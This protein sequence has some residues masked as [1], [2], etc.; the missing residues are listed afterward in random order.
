MADITDNQIIELSLIYNTCT[1]A[2][3]KNDNDFLRDAA[4]NGYGYVSLRNSGHN[5]DDAK[6]IFTSTCNTDGRYDTPMWTDDEDVEFTSRWIN[7]YSIIGRLAKQNRQENARDIIYWVKIYYESYGDFETR[8]RNVENG[9]C[10]EAGL[11]LPYPPPPT[12]P[13]ESIITSGRLLKGKDTGRVIVIKGITAFQ[14]LDHYASGRDID[15]VFQKFPKANRARI[16]WYTPR[17]DWG[18]YAWELPT[19]EKTISFH[20]YLLSKGMYVLNTCLTD[21]AGSDR[22]Q[23]VKNLIWGL[24]Q[25]SLPNVHYEAKNEPFIHDDLDPSILKNAITSGPHLY[26]SG[27]YDD[28]N[29]SKFWGKY[30]EV[31]T[32]RDN[33]GVRKFKDL[34]ELC[35]QFN[36]PWHAGEPFK[37]DTGMN[38]LDFYT[39]AAGS[40]LMG[41][42][43]TFHCQS[44]ETLAQPT[45][46]ELSCAAM[47]FKGLD[48]YPA[49]SS[50]GDYQHLQ[51]FE[52][53]VDNNPTTCLRCFR[54]G[55]YIIVVRANEKFVPAVNWKALDNLG[56]A[57]EIV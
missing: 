50:L 14:M 8:M 31:H 24:N 7:R 9:M 20:E 33:E 45:D 52:G 15:W 4:Y 53:I 26:T 41:S 32:P 56:V 6:D 29:L 36:C 10:V 55:K 27:I 37:P 3:N 5:P 22:I 1:P 34:E 11:P 35:T 30:G 51:E 21:N 43:A 46:S 25:T 28:V 54:K 57:Y 18:D 49:D 13:I 39:Y 38:E 47:H 42:G 19:L 12:P 48:V 2:R 17:S 44:M 16:F 40:V 23:A